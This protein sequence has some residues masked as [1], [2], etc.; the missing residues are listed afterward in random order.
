MKSRPQ[1]IRSYFTYIHSDRRERHLMYQKAI[2]FG[3]VQSTI[4][5]KGHHTIKS[6]K[7]NNTWFATSI[8]YILSLSI[9]LF[10]KKSDFMY[11]QFIINFCWL[12]VP[13]KIIKVSERLQIMWL[14]CW[15]KIFLIPISPRS[16]PLPRHLHSIQCQ[17]SLGAEF[18]CKQF[19]HTNISFWGLVILLL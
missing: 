14:S 3:A 13:I 18:L 8:R 9:P 17:P 16:P 2:T 1:Q 7:L 4:Y 19:K 10:V 6:W 11:M 12:V 5:F 15:C